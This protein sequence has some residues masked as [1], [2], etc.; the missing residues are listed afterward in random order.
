MSK[1][2]LKRTLAVIRGGLFHQES[3]LSD[4]K[5][6]LVEQTQPRQKQKKQAVFKI[7]TNY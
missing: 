6:Y 2:K 3:A 7:T 1:G 5:I 4:S